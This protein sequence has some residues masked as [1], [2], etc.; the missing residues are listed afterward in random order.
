M[1]WLE[2]LPSASR[3]FGKAVGSGQ[4]ANLWEEGDTS[5]QCLELEDCG[6]NASHVPC[7]WPRSP[8]SLSLPQTL[9][10]RPALLSHRLGKREPTSLSCYHYRWEHVWCRGSM[11]VRPSLHFLIHEGVIPPS[12]GYWVFS[13]KP[14]GSWATG[15]ARLGERWFL[16]QKHS[17][18]PQT[19]LSSSAD[20]SS[21][22]VF[23][24][25]SRSCIWR[26]C[27]CERLRCWGGQR[28]VPACKGDFRG[29][30]KKQNCQVRGLLGIS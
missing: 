12:P 11:W 27:Q 29:N 5:C 3:E 21:Q 10:H 2:F 7:D 8:L 18:S 28:G 1:K 30:C 9:L 20:P 16:Q 22:S 14:V 25:N 19:W 4:P 17:Q 6:Q 13:R 15:T 23:D 26:E 24:K